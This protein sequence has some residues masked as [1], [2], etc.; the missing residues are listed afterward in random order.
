MDEA[1]EIQ[2]SQQV[3]G[4]LVDVFRQWMLGYQV[5]KLPEI[6]EMEE[7]VVKYNDDMKERRDNAKQYLG[8]AELKKFKGVNKTKLL[9]CLTYLQNGV[10]FDELPDKL[11]LEPR[12]WRRYKSDLNAVGIFSQQVNRG[13]AFGGVTTDFARYYEELDRMQGDLLVNKK[14]Y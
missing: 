6:R 4:R 3:L 7:I 9:M 10:P 11:K 12:T 14:R 1:V 5:E 2:F 8:A 13:N